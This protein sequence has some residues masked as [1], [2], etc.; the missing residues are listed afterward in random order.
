VFVTWRIVGGI[1]IGAAS[2]LAPM[3]ISEVAPA[4]LRGRLASLQQMAIVFGL[5]SAFLSNDLLARIAGGAGAAFWLGRA[6]WRWMFWM[7]AIPSAAF[8][9][10]TFL[11]PES[12][13]FLVMS[14]RREQAL[15]VF[16]RIGGNVAELVGQV[17]QSLRGEH[18]PE[19][20]DLMLSGTRRIAP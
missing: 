3:Y 17:E 8:L 15:E 1:E 4:H 10:G 5:F 13:R 11:I 19:L 16:A 20:S 12:P 7:E 2:V 14:G 18:R 9:I 6:A